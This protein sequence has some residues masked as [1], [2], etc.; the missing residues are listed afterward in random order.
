M[1]MEG[2][3]RGEKLGLGRDQGAVR[4]GGCSVG[5]LLVPCFLPF[6]SL[7]TLMRENIS[8]AK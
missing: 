4:F 8:W 6:S 5:I 1:G 7:H 3:E 2:L